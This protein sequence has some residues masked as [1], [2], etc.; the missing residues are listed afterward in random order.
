MTRQKSLK[1][2][3]FIVPAVLLMGVFY[4][5]AD[6]AGD[7]ISDPSLYWS[8]GVNDVGFNGRNTSSEH[9]Y[10][11][12][13]YSSYDLEVTWEWAHKVRLPNGSLFRNISEH[14]IVTVQAGVDKYDGE[15]KSTNLPGGSYYIDAY[16]SVDILYQQRRAGHPRRIKYGK[17]SEE[18]SVQ[19][20]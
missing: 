9:R 7:Y 3:L 19:N 11:I 18:S 15:T 12:E 1:L 4:V 2:A 6:H 20:I 16:T 17:A 13:N 8:V 14:G 5:Q 10:A